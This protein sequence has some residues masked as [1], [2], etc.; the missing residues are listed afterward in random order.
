MAKCAA[1]KH[2][3]QRTARECPDVSFLYL[4]V[5]GE[6][7]SGWRGGEARKGCVAG[8]VRYGTLE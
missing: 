4:E 7:P 5:G 3:I 2:T 8:T 1:V 6:G